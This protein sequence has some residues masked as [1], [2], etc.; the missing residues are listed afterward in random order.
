ML[1][2]INHSRRV[3]LQRTGIAVAGLSLGST[4]G[5]A[6]DNQENHHQ[7]NHEGKTPWSG[8][9]PTHLTACSFNIRYDNPDD[10]YSWDERVSRVIKTVE[11][12]EPGVLGMQEA[13]PHQ[14]DDLRDGIDEYEWYGVG[15]ED[16]DR[17]GEMVPIAWHPDRFEAIETGEFWL[18]E[19]PTKPSVGWDAD[20]PRVTT[21]VSLRHRKTGRH[22]WFCNTH[23]SHVG[24]TARSESAKLIRKRACQRTE[25]GEDVVITGD[26]NTKPSWEPYQ[27]MTGTNGTSES[28][29]ADPR[30]EADT[31]SVS[32]TWGTYHGFTNDIEDRIDYI[33]TGDTATVNSYRTLPIQE[34]EYRS[35]H[36][37][38]VTDVEY[39]TQWWP[40]GKY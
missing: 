32:G 23:F 16:G 11:N 25:E 20:L 6:M 9:R 18:S 13:L 39:S 33:F 2:G 31:D 38:V 17:K 21:W 35:D 22:L 3:F 8:W 26:F 40:R 12:S 19:T 30:R 5:T 14:Y 37:P 28:P 7:T 27:I 10:E 24:E 36:L 29:L 1:K 4:T 34:N 15:R